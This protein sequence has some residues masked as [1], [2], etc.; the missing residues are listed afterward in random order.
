MSP[1]YLGHNSFSSGSQ[2]GRGSCRIALNE[3]EREVYLRDDQSTDNEIE[4]VGEWAVWA[5]NQGISKWASWLAW[6][7]KKTHSGSYQKLSL[8]CKELRRNSAWS[9]RL[10]CPLRSEIGGN[11]NEDW[12]QEMLLESML[13]DPR[14]YSTMGWQSIPPC[15]SPLLEWKDVPNRE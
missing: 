6:P 12:G 2:A 10:Q 15:L 7:D 1:V 5:W 14:C 3:R 11:S 4:G 13:R 8:S 9:G